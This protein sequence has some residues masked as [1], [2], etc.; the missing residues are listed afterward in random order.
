MSHDV[1]VEESFAIPLLEV[2][3]LA[4]L[5]TGGRLRLVAVG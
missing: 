3:G 1:E 2:S 5:R 4:L